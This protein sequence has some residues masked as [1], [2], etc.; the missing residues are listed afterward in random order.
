LG[1][2]SAIDFAIFCKITVLP[3]RGGATIKDLCPAPTGAIISII[4]EDKSVSGFS[5]SKLNFFSG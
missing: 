2:F 1:K 3:D 5:V 4:L